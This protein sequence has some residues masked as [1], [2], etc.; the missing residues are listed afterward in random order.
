MFFKSTTL[1]KIKTN[2]LK[3]ESFWS[4]RVTFLFWLYSTFYSDEPIVETKS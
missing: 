1:V 2:E 4:L 3:I